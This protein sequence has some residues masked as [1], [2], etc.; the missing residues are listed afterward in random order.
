M[1]AIINLGIRLNGQIDFVFEISRKSEEWTYSKHKLL[2][3]IG[4]YL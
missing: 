2:L 3:I 1:Q 4:R